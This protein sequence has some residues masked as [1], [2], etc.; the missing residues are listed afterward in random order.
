MFAKRMGATVVEVKSSHVAMTSH[1]KE[2][3]ELIEKAATAIIEKAP[4]ATSK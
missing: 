2:T 1:P 4:A 3:A